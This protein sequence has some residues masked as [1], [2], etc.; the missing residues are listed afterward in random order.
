MQLPMPIFCRFR[1]ITNFHARAL[2][3]VLL[4]VRFEVTVIIVI[5]IFLFDPRYI[6]IIIIGRKVRFSPLYRPQSRLS[7]GP[8]I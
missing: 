7:I 5:I 1:D 8:T 2:V 4:F 3:T 6:I